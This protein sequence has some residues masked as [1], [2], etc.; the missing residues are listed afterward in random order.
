MK[1]KWKCA[2]CGVARSKR[3]PIKAGW[4]IFTGAVLCAE[5]RE[6]FPKPIKKPKPRHFDRYTVPLTLTNGSLHTKLLHSWVHS[7]QLRYPLK[8]TNA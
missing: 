6:K 4:A 1:T 3:N 2:C 5:C 8:D 7:V